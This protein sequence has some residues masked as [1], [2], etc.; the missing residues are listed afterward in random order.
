MIQVRDALLA[1]L[2]HLQLLE[3]LSAQLPTEFQAR[4]V[5]LSRRVSAAIVGSFGAVIEYGL[6]AHQPTPSGAKPLGDTSPIL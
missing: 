3:D 2:G 5:E 6:P 4:T 1:L